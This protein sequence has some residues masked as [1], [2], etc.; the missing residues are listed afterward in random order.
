M[1]ATLELTKVRDEGDIFYRYDIDGT[2]VWF[3]QYPQNGNIYT[4]AIRTNEELDGEVEFYL[5]EDYHGDKCYPTGIYISA[6]HRRLFP[7]QMDEHIE[8]MK[9]AKEVA[10]AIMDIFNGGVHKECYEKFHK[11]CE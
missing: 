2:K 5:Q 6:G 1:K 4:V 8:L 3:S 7:E 9:Y 10:V 11:T